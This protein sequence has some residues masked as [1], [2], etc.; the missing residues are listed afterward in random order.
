M[1]SEKLEYGIKNGITESFRY[2]GEDLFNVIAEAREHKKDLSLSGLDKILVDSD[3][4]IYDKYEGE[5]VPLDFPDYDEDQTDV[6]VYA[7]EIAVEH[8]GKEVQLNKPQKGDVKKFKVYVR[9]PSS[10]NVKKI[11][12]G[13]NTNRSLLE[14]PKRRE[15]F[16]S[17]HNCPSANDKT[18]PKYW[19]CRTNRFFHKIFGGKPIGGRFW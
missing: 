9:D 4:G 12:F 7:K 16:S 11:N 19:S 8:N 13:L 14:D 6:D 18:T 15:A 3:F 2:G 17:R 5:Y 1:Y 10:G